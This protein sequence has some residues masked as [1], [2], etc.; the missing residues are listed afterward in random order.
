MKWLRWILLVF[1]VLVGLGGGALGFTLYDQY[2]TQLPPLDG[3]LEYRP[4]VAT[5]VYADD[6]SLVGEFFFEKRYLTP[7]HE[8]SPVVRYAFVAAED[9]DFYSH[10]GIDFSSIGRAFVANMR[11]GDVVQGGST[12]TQQVVKA[13]LLTPERS[14]RRKLREVM[15]SMR[16]EREL[17][18][19]E[20]LYLYLNEIYLGDGNYGVG[21][22]A[23]AYF[24]KKVNE[25][26]LPEAA[27]LAGLPQ[28]PSRYSPTRNPQ[29]ALTR[30]RYV[31]R[32]MFDEGFI[33]Q[34]EYE[35][36][37]DDGVNVLPRRHAA[38][39]FGSYYIEYVRQYLETHFGKQ[40]PY[41]QGFRVYTSMNLAMQRAAEEAVRTGV[42][43]VDLRLGYRGPHERIPPE[44]LEER[45]ATDRKRDDLAELVDGRAYDAIVTGVEPRSIDVE[46]GNFIS[47]IDVSSLNWHESVEDRRFRI[48]DV[49]MVKASGGAGGFA[50]LL[51]QEPEL[52]SALLA[53]DPV[54]GQVKA[55]VGGYDYGRS[56]FNRAV[57]AKRQP[58]SA[59]KPFVYAA[60]LDNGYTPASIVLDAPIQYIDHD[61]IWRPQNYS[62]R[63]YGPTTL[64]KALEKSRNVVTVRVVQD[65][66][67][68][69]VVDYV[70][71]FG[72]RTRI[73]A[74]LSVGLGTSEV[75]L[76]EL[77]NAYSIF[78]NSGEWVEPVLINR[79]EDSSGWVMLDK[80]A[81]KEEKLSAQTAYLI[82]SM[83][84]GVVQRG[85]GRSVRSLKRPVAGKTGTTNEQ[86]DGW[87]IGY[88]P[89]LVSGVWVGFDDDRTLGASGTGGK[90]AAPIWLDFMLRALDGKP[91]LDFEVP[92]GIGCVHIDAESGL[93]ARDTDLDGVLEC[94][95]TGTEPVE[96]APEWKVDPHEGSESLTIEEIVTPIDPELIEK[97]R[98]GQIFQ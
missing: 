55:M 46:L 66:G 33:T 77:T 11:A 97:Y 98:S 6:G 85:T 59:F 12:I 57:Q 10:R 48:G 24:N 28:A 3:L 62:R 51:T 56:Q 18:K 5:R 95:K 63:F 86:R 93:R 40:A 17:S 92:E 87:F 54:S 61:K 2:W 64:R 72:F 88:V 29:G 67:A 71:R 90:V 22:A 15:L 9:S 35:L 31:L 53:I 78:A 94:F 26:T 1:C 89:D 38:N 44:E 80:E 76:L 69:T 8:I 73:R 50:F 42:R 25:L 41:H 36:A 39:K 84:E 14:Y 96:F 82:T 47:N 32:R 68:D 52:E 79:I 20:I 91:V 58:G 34:N 7:I 4:P 74:N 43:T 30:Q 19:N 23:R 65:L 75:T 81:R 16:L 49:V 70:R 21:A 27:L 37:L 13:L 45:L 60:A 83:L